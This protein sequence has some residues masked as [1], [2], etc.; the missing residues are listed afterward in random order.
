MPREFCIQEAAG[1]TQLCAGQISGTV[2]AVHSIN[3]SFKAEVYE[4]VLL[5]DASNAF[6]SLGHQA[7][8]LTSESCA[9]PSQP[10]S[11]KPTKIMQ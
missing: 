7:A 11:P 2:A 10:S 4:G 9:F 3:F 6:N 8:I 1:S 5:V